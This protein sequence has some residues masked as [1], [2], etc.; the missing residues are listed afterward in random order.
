MLPYRT[1]RYKSIA[2]LILLL[3]WWG[4]GLKVSG[5]QFVVKANMLSWLTLT[6]SIE[7]EMKIADKFTADVNLMYRPWHVLAD[8]K[9]VEGIAVQSEVRYW[10][11]Q[12]FYKH[13]IGVHFNY[14]DYNGGL[15]KHRYQGNLFGA[16]FTYGYQ[17]ILGP[18]WNLEFNVGVGYARMN[19]DKYER[20]K[21]GPFIGNEKKN[22]FGPTKLGIT[23]VY[24]IN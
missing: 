21:C 18:K 12:T 5:Q 2:L 11:C 8:N 1:L 15:D 23:L 13:F 22:Y 4:G 14:A 10:F 19:H 9:K 20:R 16:G 24:L 17:M 7:G 3:V 6:P